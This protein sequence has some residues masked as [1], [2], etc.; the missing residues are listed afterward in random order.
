MAR[1]HLC[2]GEGGRGWAL[3]GWHVQV[4]GKARGCSEV[5][6]E[7]G[8][9]NGRGV[10]RCARCVRAR[11]DGVIRNPGLAA[12]GGG[13]HGHGHRNGRSGERGK[14]VLNRMCIRSRGRVI[15]RRGHTWVRA[16]GDHG[17]EG[18]EEA[19]RRERGQRQLVGLGLSRLEWSGAR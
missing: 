15:C 8:A 12:Q 14:D 13:G 9:G 7:C 10:H 2:R 17:S 11:E 3:E 6:V 5:R 4:R 19:R 16:T 18:V 1:K